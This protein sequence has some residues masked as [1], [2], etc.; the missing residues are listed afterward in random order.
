MFFF[1]VNVFTS[2]PHGA[3]KKQYTATARTILTQLLRCTL[4]L[5]GLSQATFSPV[6]TRLYLEVF[7]LECLT[8]HCVKKTFFIFSTEKMACLYGTMRERGLTA[9]SVQMVRGW[10]P[11]TRDVASHPSCGRKVAGV[12]ART[13]SD[14]KRKWGCNKPL[15][16]FE[17]GTVPTLAGTLAY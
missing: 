12:T 8:P 15:I 13:L 5:F 1:F 2:W 3:G 7:Q 6:N 16:S 10:C 4:S 14:R 11:D 17:C 9:P